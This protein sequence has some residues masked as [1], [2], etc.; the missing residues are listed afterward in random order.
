MI[1]LLQKNGSPPRVS[2]PMIAV[3]ILRPDNTKTDIC[4]PLAS[5]LFNLLGGKQ[6]KTEP[7]PPQIPL[8]DLI[9]CSAW[10]TFQSDSE[11]IVISFVLEW[12]SGSS[13]TD[14]CK[15]WQDQCEHWIL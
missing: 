5:E 9:L 14:F 15:R 10:K 13:D 11:R 7:V 12:D 8:M 4:V 6:R 3:T 1:M 2:E